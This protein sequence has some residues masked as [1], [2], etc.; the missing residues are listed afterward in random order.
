M[1]P[2]YSHAND[3]YTQVLE[4]GPPSAAL[5]FHSPVV[6]RAK[7]Q[8]VSCRLDE[9]NPQ[10]PHKTISALVPCTDDNKHV[11]QVA[12]HL[13]GKELNSSL[14]GTIVLANVLEPCCPMDGVDQQIVLYRRTNEQV[15][16]KV[17]RRKLIRDLHN[18]P[19]GHA[20]PE[21]PWKEVSCIQ[22]LHK[23]DSHPYVLKLVTAFVDEECLYEVMPF[24]AGGSLHQLLS[25]HPQGLDEDV[26]GTYFRQIILA[27]DYIHSKGVCHRDISTQNILLNENHSKP[28]L[29]DFGMALR[30]PYSY[31]DDFLT[32]DVT[33]VSMGTVRRMI[34]SQSHCGKLRFMAPE[35][36]RAEDYD[37]LTI[38]IWSTGCVLF[39]MLTGHSPYEKPDLMDSGYHDLLDHKFYWDPKS[40]NP[41]FSWGR[42]T[43]SDEAV[44]LL[45]HMFKPN[46][47]DRLTL[48][49]I[50]AHPWLTEK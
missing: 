2:E 41:L 10:S 49:Q 5:G 12:Y 7:T 34:H 46:P 8:T 4:S 11:S 1:I 35:M 14:C 13:T 48:G 22:L 28:V 23:D 32:E 47:K 38:D 29:I 15:A 37:G 42:S 31:P 19:N 21:N 9:A 50:M 40:V 26:A 20:H 45:Q 27:I 17:D 24:Y 6:Y 25:K 43:I 33:D 3:F 39:A 44:D 36:Y 16:I 18:S 30:V